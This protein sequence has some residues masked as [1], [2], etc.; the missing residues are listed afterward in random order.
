[1]CFFSY[2]LLS[3]C[4]LSSHPSSWFLHLYF[5]TV[6]EMREK[7]K[8]KARALCRDFASESDKI[9]VVFLMQ[10]RHSVFLPIYTHTH[11][12]SVFIDTVLL[13]IL[14]FMGRQ[15]PELDHMHSFSL[16]CFLIFP[17]ENCVVYL[18]C[19]TRFPAMF[20]LWQ[21]RRHQAAQ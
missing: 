10:N 18:K 15:M 19:K 8:Q 7:A 17:S 14:D 11:G 21:Q 3:P 12:L 9:A 5:A 2:A 1:M 13:F 6:S 16:Q 20:S 4:S